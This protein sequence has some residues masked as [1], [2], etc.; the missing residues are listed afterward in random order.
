MRCFAE[1][2]S[3]RSVNMLVLIPMTCINNQKVGLK[4]IQN[5]GKIYCSQ[6][7]GET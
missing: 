5:Q 7:S 3:G 1:S 4:I 2:K 6:D